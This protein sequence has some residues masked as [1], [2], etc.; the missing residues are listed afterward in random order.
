[1]MILEHAV[2][3]ACINTCWREREGNSRPSKLDYLPLMNDVMKH[4]LLLP[5]F[6]SLTAP[7]AGSLGN[8]GQM[9]LLVLLCSHSSHS[10]HSSHR[11]RRRSSHIASY[12]TKW[13]Q[14][15]CF[16]P[17]QNTSTPPSPFW[18]APSNL[19]GH[20]FPAWKAKTKGKPQPLTQLHPTSACRFLHYQT[21]TWQNIWLEASQGLSHSLLLPRSLPP[22]SPQHPGMKRSLWRLRKEEL[23]C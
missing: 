4:M 13:S 9:P 2:R 8:K 19:I 15:F 22:Q 10:R 5:F 14:S 12:P 23:K 1:M 11:I 17:L 21:E 16:P 20:D 6:F 7:N 18:R 3:C